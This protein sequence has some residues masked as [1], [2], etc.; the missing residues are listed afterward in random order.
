VIDAA[1]RG[2]ALEVELLHKFY[3]LLMEHVCIVPF[4]GIVN[5]Y[6]LSVGGCIKIHIRQTRTRLAIKP[7]L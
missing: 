7:K 2:T 6:A 4:V 3:A 5:L 1:G